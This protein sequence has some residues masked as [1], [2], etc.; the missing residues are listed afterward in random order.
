MLRLF[1][2][3]RR[4]E[5][6]LALFMELLGR[7]PKRLASVGRCAAAL[8]IEHDDQTCVP[9]AVGARLLPALAGNV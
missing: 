2:A 3:W 9:G 7:M 8:P 1:M 6:Q 5:D 4:D